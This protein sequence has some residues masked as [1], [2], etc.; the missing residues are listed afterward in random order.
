MSSRRT[1]TDSPAPAAKKAPS[2]KKA[3]RAAQKTDKAEA[4]S[5]S[6]APAMMAREPEPSVVVREPAGALHE[7]ATAAR[8]APV[9]AAR[10]QPPLQAPRIEIS[11]DAR[12]A[13]VAEAAYLRAERRGFAYGNEVEDWLAAEAEVDKLLQGSHGTWA[14]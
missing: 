14:Q 5:V 1:S 3:S 6:A 7:P 10:H 13:L 9:A 4:V 8:E 11:P 12:R 2:R